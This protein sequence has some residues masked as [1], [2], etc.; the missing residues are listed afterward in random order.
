[1]IDVDGALQ[2]LF[3]LGVALGFGVPLVVD[4]CADSFRRRRY[5]GQLQAEPP[6]TF[7]IAA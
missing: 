1:M 5:A 3:D 4:E 6:Q 7:R 2:E